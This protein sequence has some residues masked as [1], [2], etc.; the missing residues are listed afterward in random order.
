MSV[1]V[2]V[3]T[4]FLGA[5]KTTL[6]NRL[7]HSDHGRRLAVIVNEFGE[8]GIDGE[9]LA[10]GGEELIEL[11]N[12]CV[13]CTVRG[14]LLRT[15]HGLRGRRGAIDGVIIETTGLADP[16]PVAQTFLFDEALR[17][18][19]ALDGIVTVVDALHVRDQLRDRPEAAEQVAFA[20]LI[21]LS[22]ADL[23]NPWD[24]PAI[25]GA[26][27]QVNPSARIVTA[28]RGEIGPETVLDLGGF[29]LARIASQI[30]DHD[31]TDHVHGSDIGTVTLTADVP[32]DQERV[33]D[34]LSGHLAVHGR[35]VLRVKG[36]L[37]V[38]G[39]ARRLVLQ[40]VHMILEGDHLSPWPPGPRQS[41]LVLIGRGLDRPALQ[42]AFE[43]CI[44]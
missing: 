42:A 13:C 30:H 21:V 15:L 2:T 28:E 19:F 39:D 3:L 24:L 6:L 29:D 17:A 38:A 34:W 37:E 1:L 44:A 7:L 32:L 12:G 25:R 4:G 33:T 43:A 36:I 41:R 22:K 9:L 31:C 16:G 40:G 35:D 11:A 5:G 18:D 20:D 8:A 23:A 10:S 26:L 27:A 14:D